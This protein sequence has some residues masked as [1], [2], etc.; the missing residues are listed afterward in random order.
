MANYQLMKSWGRPNV[1]ERE[2]VAQDNTAK[3]ALL[4]N[5]SL[6]F[7]DKIY[8]IATQKRYLIGADGQPYEKG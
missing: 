6:Q 1:Q 4:T 5:E 3:D 8:V 7:G 2:W